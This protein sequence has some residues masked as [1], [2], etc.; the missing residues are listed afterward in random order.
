MTGNVDGGNRVMKDDGG[1]EDEKGD[2]ELGV[3]RRQ[4]STLTLTTLG[5]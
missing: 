3:H 2:K 4:S 5:V 1:N